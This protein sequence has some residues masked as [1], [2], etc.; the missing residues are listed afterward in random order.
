MN[1]EKHDG[2]TPQTP[3]PPSDKPTPGKKPVIVYIMILFIAA[4]LLMALSFLMHQRSNTEAL[5]E[6][7]T[8]V[9]AL[10]EVQATQDKNMLLQDE[11]GKAEATIKKLEQQAAETNQHAADLEAQADA[12]LSLYCLQQE[13]AAGDLDGCKQILQN[14]EDNGKPQLLPTS[15]S[16]DGS[17]TAPLQRYEQ[18]RQA[19]LNP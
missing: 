19:V 12:L 5:G 6:L 8:S 14:M 3:T 18:L 9:S 7:Q 17:I 15:A 16:A 11:L 10:R 4:F 13:Y 2:E 1:I